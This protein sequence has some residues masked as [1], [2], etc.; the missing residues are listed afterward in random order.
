LRVL[1][2]FLII[3]AALFVIFDL[4][5][6]PAETD[7]NRIVVSEGVVE[8]LAAQFRRTWLRPPTEKELSGLI[9]NHV[10]DEVYYREALAMGLDQNDRM[11]RQRMRQKLEFILEDLTAAES[12]GDDT[13]TDFLQENAERFQVL[14]RFSLQQ[15]YLN[16]DKRQDLEADAAA[17]LGDL[18]AGAEPETLGDQT[19]LPA[20]L[21]DADHREIARVF[22][23]AFA[24]QMASLDTGVWV[25]PV[26]SGLGAHLVRVTER[27]DGRLP[28]LAEVRDKVET[29]YLAQRS[30]ELKE[31]AYRRLREGYEVVIEPVAVP[32]DATGAAVAETRPAP[33]GG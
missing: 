4:T 30:Q 18:R 20:A 13:L 10:R 31:Q 3:G 32:A 22:G 25:G 33:S 7:A 26:Y 17:L 16:P 14:P 6:E 11:V 29:E 23:S 28:G 19:L 15:I 27:R 9:E 5:Q 1:P 12:P 2:D 24:D 21:S 8:Q